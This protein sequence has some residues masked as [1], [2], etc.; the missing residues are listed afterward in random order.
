MKRSWIIG[1]VILLWVFASPVRAEETK[2][3]DNKSNEDTTLETRINIGIRNTY[4]GMWWPIP[5]PLAT[6]V[7]FDFLRFFR[8]QLDMTAYVLKYGGSKVGVAGGASFSVFDARDSP[9]GTFQ[10][11]IP[12]LADFGYMHASF[13]RGDGYGDD[14]NCLFLGPSTGADFT[15]WVW[16]NLGINV[17]LKAGYLF[18]VVDMESDYAPE[19]YGGTEDQVGFFESSLVMGIAMDL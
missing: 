17:S 8:V 13:E 16:Q 14:L 2:T 9:G 4:I 1:I 6:Q 10:F 18:K 7:S 15:W 3:Q 5:S 19:D 11:N 12:L